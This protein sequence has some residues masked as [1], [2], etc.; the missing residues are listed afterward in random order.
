M[1][2]K[3]VKK[4]PAKPKAK[5]PAKPKKQYLI[6]SGGEA[7]LHAASIDPAIAKMDADLARSKERLAKPSDKAKPAPKK[8]EAKKKPA[9]PAVSKGT[10]ASLAASHKGKSTILHPVQAMW[11]L[12]DKM[13]DHQRKD[14]IQKAVESGISYYTARTQYQEWLTAFR[15]S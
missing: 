7:L 15:N 12:C 5:S 4:A 3:T 1:A 6:E 14:V 8:S 10:Y 13:Q 9:A 11:N 2:S